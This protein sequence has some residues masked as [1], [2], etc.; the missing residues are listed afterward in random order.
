MKNVAVVMMIVVAICTAALAH[1][2][3]DHV[4]GTVTKVTAGSIQV[5]TA[6][7]ETKDVMIDDKTTY[8]KGGKK[9]SVSD[10]TEGTRVVIEAHPMQNMLHAESVKIGVSKTSDAADGAHANKETKKK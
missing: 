2:G 3:H 4:M 6:N 10:V 8:T 9:A 1:A 7:G 5:K